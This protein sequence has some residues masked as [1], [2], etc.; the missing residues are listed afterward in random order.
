MVETVVQLISTERTNPH[1]VNFY[2]TELKKYQKAVFT[3]FTDSNLKFDL[4]ISISA[5]VD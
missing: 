2:C 1:K 5:V 4:K 3:D